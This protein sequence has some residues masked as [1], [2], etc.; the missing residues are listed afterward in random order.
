[1][2]KIN[3]E[4][5]W[6]KYC[7]WYHIYPIG[8]CG[9]PR[10]NL[11][12][13]HVE[14]RIEELYSLE[15]VYHLKSLK[16]GG[17][18]IGPV[19]ESY[20]H[21]YDTSDLYKIDKRLG[22][23]DHFKKLVR[24]YHSFGI[25]VVIDTVFNHVG[26]NFFAFKDLQI[27]GEISEYYT[28]FKNI[29]FNESSPKGDN[30]NYTPWHGYYE[31]VTLD[32]DNYNVK[33]YLYDAVK[34]WYNEFNIDGLRLDAADCLSIDF[35][36]QFRQYCKNNFGE[37]FVLI[38]EIVHGDGK[39]WVKPSIYS[40][41]KSYIDA[42][43]PF[44]GI[45]NYQLWSAIWTSHNNMNVEIIVDAIIQQN[46]LLN[47]GWMYNFVDNH[48][49]SRISSQVDREEYLYTIYMILFTI[50]G[51][52]SIYYGSEFNFKGIK[53]C[54][55]EA[56]FPLRP[57]IS[58]DDLIR[59]KNKC[60]CDGLYNL[61]RFLSCIRIYPLIGEILNFGEYN[62]VFNTNKLFIYKRQLK[63]EFILV[64]IN[65]DSEYINDITINWNG[66]NGRWRDILDPENSFNSENGKLTLSIKPNWGII[67]S[68][69]IPS[70]IEYEKFR[71]NNQKGQVMLYIPIIDG[72]TPVLCS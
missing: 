56:D 32:H 59:Y 29:D 39:L 72:N 27:K 3:L 31:L 16:I 48:D 46:E 34:Y 47:Y 5:E 50:Q 17:V 37:K 25:K 26:R 28:W 60:K 65:I 57:K 9:A 51:S 36:K 8:L 10:Y 43:Q 33:K 19:F 18:Y 22:S 49:V 6:Y 41:I 52:P 38:G 15:W 69:Y 23:N 68:S 67:I 24:V 54:G 40:N 53:G 2:A 21:G 14:N 58:I 30:F 70:A 66:P 42:N 35:W 1:M 20:S 4:N 12:D 13:G 64:G 61:I 44:D 55:K 71:F 63:E 45:T 7:N 11:E 62:H